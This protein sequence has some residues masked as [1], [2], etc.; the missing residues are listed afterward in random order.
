MSCF[1]TPEEPSSFDSRRSS[2]VHTL[3]ST[4]L[5]RRPRAMGIVCRNHQ[6]NHQSHNVQYKQQLLLAFDSSHLLLRYLRTLSRSTACT[7]SRVLSNQLQAGCGRIITAPTRL[8]EQLLALS[9]P[10]D[11]SKL[12][13]RSPSDTIPTLQTTFHTFTR[14]VS[15]AFYTLLSEEI[16]G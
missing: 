3:N 14:N 12:S 15:V 4:T 2:A 7:A 10:T 11:V 1:D 16:L 8:S 6:S 13:E 5:C 9:L